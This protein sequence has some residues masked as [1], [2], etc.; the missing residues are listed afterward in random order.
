MS[1]RADAIVVGGGV[2]GA[3]VLFEL[4]RRNLRALLLERGRFASESTAKTAAIV[5]MHYSNPEVVRMA[6]R[7][8]ELLQSFGE[9]TGAESV[10]FETGWCYVVPPE[11]AET[12]RATAEMNRAHGVEVV[13]VGVDEAAELYPGL[14]GEGVGAIFLEERSGS[15][16]P[17]ATALGYIE[18]AR[19]LGAEAREDAPA[20]R[21]LERNGGVG[22]VETSAGPIE[23]DVVV[24]A[25]GPWSAKLA[26]TAGV[27]LQ[28]QIT[29]EQELYVEAPAGRGPRASM[30]SLVDMIYLRPLVE[31]E[32]TRPN[33]VLLGRGFP[34]DYEE[35]D[36]D[37]YDE[38]VTPSFEED[39][40]RRVSRRLPTL[41]GA[42]AL[43]G[44]SGL[45]D[46]TPDW[47]PYLGLVD[48]VDGLVL[49]TGGSGH[50]YKLAPAIGEMIAATV[51]GE[52][53]DYADVDR[54]SLARIARGDLFDAAI[55]GNRA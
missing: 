42:R 15:A 52:D 13:E 2:I 24:L 22:G 50:C 54:F 12:V 7:S 53:V 35:V 28:L 37:D 32:R 34:K 1:R 16:D 27:E 11:H 39:V 47:H 55:G 43:G 8:R 48:G 29:R 26:Q 18:A 31:W 46:I 51:T 49:A 30:S 3:A 9:L 25:A 4:A 38:E 36:P 45:Y 40:R 10:Y 19:R 21:L 23:A 41:E 44:V 6:L 33:V 5:R 20:T 14:S 17:R